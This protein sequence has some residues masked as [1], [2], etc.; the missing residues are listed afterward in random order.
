MKKER[1]DIE[2]TAASLSAKALSN[3]DMLDLE[4]VALIARK[5]EAD[6]EIIKELLHLLREERIDFYCNLELNRD[7]IKELLKKVRA[8]SE[9]ERNALSGREDPAALYLKETA[10]LER[11][12][13]AR[14]QE[15]LYEICLGNEDAAGELIEGSLY[16]PIWAAEKYTGRGVL[17]L[18]LVQEGNLVIM[19]VTEGLNENDTEMSFS[20]YCAWK[21]CSMMEKI[22]EDSEPDVKIPFTA[23]EDLA[24][25]AGV[26]K[27][28]SAKGEKPT[29]S[30]V[31]KETGLSEERVNELLSF[32][33]ENMPEEKADDDKPKEKDETEE[34][35]SQQVREM[36]ESLS[37]LEA[38][39]I[40]L[41]FG[42]SG[43]KPMELP[44]IA[45]KLS[46]SE[47]EAAKLEQDAMKR[48][49]R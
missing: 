36:L 33:R 8:S 21:I 27:K 3:G 12:D 4:E 31:A 47:E 20:A 28:L 35:L 34:A 29:V 2:Q 26:Y 45:E 14:E 44:E 24:K 5:Y 13:S 25:A 37:P 1:L 49:G 9:D 42:L 19:T 48:L 7:S 23:A 18:D 40:G 39:V 10:Q 15:L 22:T 16:I 41:K 43:N 38:E 32:V 17:F 46:V 6:D 30:D 11:N